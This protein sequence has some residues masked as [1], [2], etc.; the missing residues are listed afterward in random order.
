MDE[1]V[2]EFLDKMSKFKEK[3]V[4]VMYGDHLPA[5]DNLTE[6]NI[7]KDRSLYQTDYVIWSNYSMPVIKQDLNCYQIGSELLNRLNIHNGTLVTYHQK[8]KKS[9]DYLKNLQALQYDILY[10]DRYIYN[11]KG[12]N[13]FKPMKMKMGVKDI[14]IDKVVKIGDKYYLKG[15]N[16]TEY[17]K[18]NLDGEILD[19]VYLGPTILGLSEEVEPEDVKRMKVSQVEKNSEILSTSE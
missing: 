17:S 10:G 19:T 15:Q 18:I 2:K 11:D 14:K 1:W 4:V 7:P 9:K 13:P 8:H 5:I 6:D 16:F 12:K 3:T